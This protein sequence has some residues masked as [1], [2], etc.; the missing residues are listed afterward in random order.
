MEAVLLVAI[1]LAI[2]LLVSSRPKKT[3]RKVQPPPPRAPMQPGGA[4]MHVPTPRRAEPPVAQPLEFTRLRWQKPTPPR[5]EPLPGP[6][7][8][9][10]PANAAKRKRTIAVEGFVVEDIR[11]VPDA[12]CLLTGK[13]V[14][15]C[16]CEQ[17]RGKAV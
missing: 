15:D 5:F 16:R 2:Y 17:H 13:E 14:R 1:A 9:R 6:T 3:R 7:R 4:G 10:S 8:H 11:Q 12:R